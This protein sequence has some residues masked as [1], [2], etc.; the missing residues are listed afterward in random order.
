MVGMPSA[1]TLATHQSRVRTGLAGKLE[2][3]GGLLRYPDCS[4]TSIL[5]TPEA[6]PPS[7]T[8][9]NAP[10][11]SVAV[12]CV[13]PHSSMLTPGTSSTCQECLRVLRYPCNQCTA[14]VEAATIAA[15]PLIPLLRLS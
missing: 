2:P 15:A 9:L 13:P 10:I 3:T 8:T 1:V 6:T 14:H 12:T 11:W 7:D 5:R 4:R